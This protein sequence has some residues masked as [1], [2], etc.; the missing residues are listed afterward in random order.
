MQ[1]VSRACNA[2]QVE[3]NAF[4]VECN[5]RYLDTDE[6]LDTKHTVWIQERTA[7]PRRRTVKSWKCEART[8]MHA[9]NTSRR[10]VYLPELAVST[11]KNI[12]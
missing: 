11:R 9:A 12:R 6:H 3:C 8:R 5:P 10:A 2:F 7:E 4:Y 1:P